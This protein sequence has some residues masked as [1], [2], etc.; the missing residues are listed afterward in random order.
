MQPLNLHE[1]REMR[2]VT[3]PTIRPGGLTLT[4]RAFAFCS[5]PE[6]A[7]VLDVGCGVGATVEFLCREHLG[8]FGV[9]TSLNAP[10]PDTIC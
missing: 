1:S 7:R 5:L 6:R 3:G 2:S 10:D 4:E 9:D 8:A